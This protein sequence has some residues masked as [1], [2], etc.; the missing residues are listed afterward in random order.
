MVWARQSLEK[1]IMLGITARAR[2]EKKTHALDGRHQK[3]NG[4]LSKLLKT[5]GERQEKVTLIREQ[6]NQEEKKDKCLIQVEG[7]GKPLL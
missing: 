1:Y 2:K 7:N 4:T 5:F 3:F 6:H